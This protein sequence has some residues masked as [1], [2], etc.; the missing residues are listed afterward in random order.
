MD[1]R[2]FETH[3]RQVI[4]EMG[5]DSGLHD[6]ATRFLAHSVRREYS[7][8]FRWLGLP[9]IQYP[10]DVVAMQ[11]LVWTIQPDAIVETGVAR[12]GSVIF[13]SSMLHLLDRGGI[14]IGVDIDIR[15]HNR[16]AIERHPLARYV[17]LVEGSSIAPSVVERVRELV[18]G[19]KR[20]L[21]VL[22]SMHTHDHVLAELR[23]YAP[24]VAAGSYVV[25]F[26][27]CVEHLPDELFPDR[28]W[29][30]GNNPWTA[31]QA[32]LRTTDRFEVDRAVTDKLQITVAPDGYLR[33]VK[34]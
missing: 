30:R 32:F 19:R 8:H 23:A 1:D 27:T 15:A 2:E 25:V 20:V 18:A 11:E 16:D 24:L 14:V 22:D 10:Q 4:G 33:C 6:L 28:P 26:D 17:R 29:R 31:V 5:E 3:N 9:I 7:Y 21:V 13:Y 34:D 12:G